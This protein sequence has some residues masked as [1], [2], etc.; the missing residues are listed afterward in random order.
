MRKKS[1]LSLA[2][3][4]VDVIDK[5]MIAHPLAFRFGSLEPDLVPTFITTKH[6][7]DLTFYKLEKKIK[8]VLEEYDSS[9]G[10]TIGLSKD[11]GVITHYL[12]D[13]FTFPHNIEYPGTMTEHIHYE[14]ELKVNFM[15]FIEHVKEAQIHFQN[16]VL[17]SAEEICNFIRKCH[18][19]YIHAVKSIQNDCNYILKICAQVIGA[20]LHLLQQGTGCQMA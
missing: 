15:L 9:K 16:V 6:R 20:I 3:Y 7:I 1:H 2:G 5:D 18:D 19:E 13:Y 14:A 4:I 8:K 11:L 10:L 12:A 17:N